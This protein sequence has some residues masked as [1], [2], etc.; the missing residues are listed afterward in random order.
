MAEGTYPMQERLRRQIGFIVEID[1]VK[2]IFRRTRIFHNK[3]YENDAE[4]AWHMCMA[5]LVLSEY[6]NEK[7]D[8]AKVV[9]MALIHDIVEIDPG[10]TYLYDK[11]QRRKAANERKCAERVFGLLPDDQRG[12]FM[13]LWEEFEAKETAEA[14]FAGAMDRLGPLMQ[15]CHDDGHAWKKHGVTSDRVLKV[16][17]QIEKGSGAI[18]EW[19]RAMIKEA[20]REGKL[21]RHKNKKQIK[22]L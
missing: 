21:H 20:V 3:R 17:R 18:W 15:N 10:D 14:K 5:A 12:E 16:N 13:A 4:H 7:I 6:S 19:A 9:K 1:K 8:I 11:N 2:S 22:S